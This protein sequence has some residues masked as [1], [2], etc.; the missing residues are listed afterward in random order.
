MQCSEAMHWDVWMFSCTDQ[1]HCS[2]AVIWCTDQ[3]QCS[4]ALRQCLDVQ[5]QEGEGDVWSHSSVRAYNLVH[6]GKMTSDALSLSL[7][8]MQ[9]S[10]CSLK[11]KRLW[12]VIY[13]HT[14]SSLKTLI[15]FSPFWR[16][17]QGW[18]K[19]TP[20]QH[21]KMADGNLVMTTSQLREGGQRWTQY[22]QKLGDS[23]GVTEVF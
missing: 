22:S 2:T 23:Y 6:S 14:L 5:V 21:N 11:L 19:G 20:C 15:W 12:I 9:A 10:E 13:V 3:L 18:R 4:T 7:L 16:W 1:L 17:V 8:H